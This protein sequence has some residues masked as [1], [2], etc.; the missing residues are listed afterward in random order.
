MA[1]LESSQIIVADLTNER[2]NC[3]LEVGYAMGL[4]KKRNLI[5]TVREDHHHSSPNYKH[6]GPHVHFDLEGYD[7]LLWDSKKPAEFREELEKRIKRRLAI[8]EPPLPGEPDKTPIQPQPAV[9]TEWI[10]EQRERALSGLAV[11]HL[12]GYME[13]SVSLLPKGTWRQSVLLSSVEESQVKTFGWPIGIVLSRDNM[14]PQ[15]TADGVRAEVSLPAG[16]GFREHGT[17]DYWYVRRTGDFYLLSSLFE[18]ERL[19]GSIFFDTRIIRITELL[20]FLAR[21]YTRLEAP[22]STQL[23]I[24][25]VHGGLRGRDLRSAGNRLMHQARTTQEEAVSSTIDCTLA[26]L[27]TNLVDLVRSLVEPLFMVFEFFD[28]PDTVLAELVNNFVEG[29]VT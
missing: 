14:R 9:D 22:D 7:R 23:H 3:Y 2:P 15:P 1:F 24:E 11:V 5:L 21:C 6:D 10:D 27:Q 12:E 29:R 25:V 18:D 19:P 28:V 4:G 17:Y 26:E 8:I 16:D 20:L 13:A